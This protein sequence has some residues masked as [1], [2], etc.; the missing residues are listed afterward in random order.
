MLFQF[1]SHVLS[2]PVVLHF[3][4]PTLYPPLSHLSPAEAR[5]ASTRKSVLI[6]AMPLTICLEIPNEVLPHPHLRRFRRSV[7]FESSPPNKS[8]LA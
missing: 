6:I 5:A 7:P 2:F 8:L 1:S 4:Q 3:H